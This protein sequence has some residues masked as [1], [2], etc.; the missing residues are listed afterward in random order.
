MT[1]PQ[2]TVFAVLIAA[3]GLFIWGRWRYDVVGMMALMAL[4]VSGIVPAREAFM[5]F[6][7]PAVITVAAVLVISRALEKTGL[8]NVLVSLLGQAGQ[9]LSWQ[10]LALCAAVVFLSSFMNNVGALALM[11]PVAMTLAHRAGRSAGTV[12]MPLAFAS[13]LG[14]MTTLIGTPPT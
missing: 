7:E 3:L 2:L 4:V 14:G 12:L 1:L 5:G 8:V 11:M 6:G 9:S 13:L 10:L